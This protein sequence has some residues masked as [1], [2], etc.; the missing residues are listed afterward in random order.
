MDVVFLM[1]AIVFVV[2]AFVF[3]IATLSKSPTVR[4]VAYKAFYGSLAHS[5][6]KP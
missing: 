4:S 2:A 3:S 5:V 6:S 1:I